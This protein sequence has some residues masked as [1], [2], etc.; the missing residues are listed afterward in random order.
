MYLYTYESAAPVVILFNVGE[1]GAVLATGRFI[2][3][4][5]LNVN[6]KQEIEDSFE[7]NLFDVEVEV[8]TK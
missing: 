7:E 1:D 5:G 6:S 3:Y 2:L 8:I 4:D